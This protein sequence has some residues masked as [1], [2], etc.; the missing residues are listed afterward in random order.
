[1]HGKTGVG[2]GVVVGLSV[3]VVGDAVVVV[4]TAVVVVVAP[5]PGIG[6]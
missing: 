3:V 1:M 4:S 6:V 2:A 5:Q